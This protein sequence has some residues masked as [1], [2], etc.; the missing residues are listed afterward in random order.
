VD[1]QQ[2]YYDFVLSE[3]IGGTELRTKMNNYIHYPWLRPNETVLMRTIDR[4]IR[5][6]MWYEDFEEYVVN[7]YGLD[8]SESRW[9]WVRFTKE[10]KSIIDEFMR[11]V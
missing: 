5:K 4:M 6:D 9:M 3:L 7:T 2:K 1:K 8:K 10:A 11:T